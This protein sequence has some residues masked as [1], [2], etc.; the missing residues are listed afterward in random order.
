MG[1]SW[2]DEDFEVPNLVQSAPPANWDDEE[3]EVEIEPKIVPSKPSQSQIEAENRR[4]EEAEK[5]LATKL[6]LA[7]LANETSEEKRLRERRQVEEADNEL[8]GELFGG[9]G[10]KATSS[11]G[12]S[13]GIG[14]ITLK[15][16][17]DHLTFG[18][19]IAQKLSSSSAFNMA[20]FYKTLTK[21]LDSPVMTA[22]ILDDIIAD[23][24]KIRDT[25]AQ[26]EKAKQNKTKKSKKDIKAA[27]KKHNAV[28]GGS[29][30]VDE[31]DD[32][33]GHL[34]DDFM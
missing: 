2:E 1:D 30:Y 28:F 29:E 20:A 15:T 4:A 14:A 23:I 8:T 16:K 3:D 21:G 7:E 32:Q 27:E 26:S 19:T 12:S 9:G 31:Y 10:K 17:Q 25:K 34:E 22:E 33:Y 13:K 5:A 18:T 6:K 24:A 11:L